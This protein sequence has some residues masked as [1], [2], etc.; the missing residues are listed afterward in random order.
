MRGTEDTVVK[1]KD[2]TQSGLNNPNPRSLILNTS[3]GRGPA[4]SLGI[5]KG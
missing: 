5:L 4:F 1:S 3:H 2:N